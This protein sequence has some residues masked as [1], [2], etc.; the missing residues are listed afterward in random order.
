MQREDS[1]TV[2]W[3]SLVVVLVWAHAAGAVTSTGFMADDVVSRAYNSL[4][5]VWIPTIALGGLIG[6]VIN[7]FAGFVR[8]GTKIAGFL[9]GIILLAG[10]LP[11][12]ASYSGGTIAT[13]FI[14]P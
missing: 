6:L 5:Q 12:L 14:L 2:L 1:R 11:L 7:F 8:I 13:S 3:L 9:F 10:G 4:L